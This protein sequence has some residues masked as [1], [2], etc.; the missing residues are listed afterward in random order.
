MILGIAAPT[1]ALSQQALASLQPYVTSYAQ[2][3]NNNVY[4][5]KV[6]YNLS[7][8]QR[9]SVRYNANRFTG[10]NFENG[11][12]TSAQG[13]T[14]D[15][16]VTTDNISGNHTWVMSPSAVL[17]TRFTYTRDDEPGQAN[18]TAPEA[19]IKQ[20]GTTAL[21]IGRNSFSPRY[22]NVKTY[23]WAESLSKVRGKHSYKMGVDMIWQR[24]GNYFPGNFSGSFTFNSYADF[25]SNKPFTF[26]QAFAGA[27]TAGALSQPNVSE[28]AFYAQDTWRLT[29]RLTLNYGVRYDLF[30]YANPPVN[31]P[32][33][34]LAA[35]GL[36]TSRINLDT[37]NIAGRLG[38]AYKLSKNGNTVLRGGVGTYYGRTPTI[39]TGTSFTQNGIQVQT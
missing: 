17:E 9:L 23:Q 31:N 35:L 24:I 1:D 21:Q 34:G 27:G 13:H 29:D 19:I 2:G 8:S 20:N 10:V 15:S 39:L 12:Q 36:D 33:A 32:D 38:F 16:D 26:T 4:L 11:G 14:G 3:L 6:D 18:S 25:A 22:T 37:N 28:Y 30:D 5:A 7:D